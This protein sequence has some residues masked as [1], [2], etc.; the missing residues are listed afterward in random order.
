MSPPP[1]STQKSSY[2]KKFT[3]S[4]TRQS[5][6]YGE[7]LLRSSRLTSIS[8]VFQSFWPLIGCRRC[9]PEYWFGPL[10]T[11]TR[12]PHGC[13]NLFFKTESSPSV[14]LFSCS[15]EI[16][17]SSARNQRINSTADASHLTVRSSRSGTLPAGIA[18]WTVDIFYSTF[19]LKRVDGMAGYPQLDIPSAGWEHVIRPDDEPAAGKINT[20]PVC[21]PQKTLPPK[22]PLHLQSKAATAWIMAIWS[23]WQ[24]RAPAPAPSLID[25]TRVRDPTTHAARPSRNHNKNIPQITPPPEGDPSAWHLDPTSDEFVKQTSNSWVNQVPSSLLNLINLK[26]LI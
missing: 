9:R 15:T 5:G 8:P 20:P 10:N 11:A 21:S 14:C 17:F 1:S 6:R 7:V 18:G 12:L 2:S 22:L 25:A 19:S 23:K 24:L 16:N 4:G 3:S 26:D 13:G